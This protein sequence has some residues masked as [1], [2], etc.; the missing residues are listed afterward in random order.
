[1]ITKLFSLIFI[2]SI[3][4]TIEQLSF[5]PGVDDVRSG[6]DGAKM[7]S[8]TE[9][10]SRFRIFDLDDRSSTPFIVKIT[11]K[12]YRYATPALTQVTDVSSRKENNCESVSYD[13][14]Q[15]YSRFELFYC[16]R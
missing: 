15:F 4:S 12:E 1:M 13:F 7:L 8:A 9:Q 2:C 5:V 3:H 14:Q 10:R 16:S 6:Y 11:D